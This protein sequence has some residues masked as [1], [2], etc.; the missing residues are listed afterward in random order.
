MPSPVV[1]ATK[2]VRLDI[3]QSIDMN[4]DVMDVVM[5]W[6]V[7]S[8]AV[9]SLYLYSNNLKIIPHQLEFFGQIATL[10]IS[11]NSFRRIPAS[12]LKFTS[13]VLEL[14]DISGCGVEEIEAGAFEGII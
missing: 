7:Q 5:D 12:S 4:D 9:S 6:A 11:N 1:G 10:D 14:I 2:R 13:N 8:F 3:V